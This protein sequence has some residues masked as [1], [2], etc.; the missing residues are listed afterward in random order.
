MM[1]SIFGVEC[2]NIRPNPHLI[3][4]ANRPLL[5]HRRPDSASSP[6][7]FGGGNLHVEQDVISM[8]PI[9][10]LPVE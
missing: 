6:W 9:G 3:Q 5:R 7:P 2:D 8:R 4:S 1:P 10:G